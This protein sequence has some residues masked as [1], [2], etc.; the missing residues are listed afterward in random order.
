MKGI[1]YQKSEESEA[2]SNPFYK[3]MVRDE[4]SGR[5]PSQTPLMSDYPP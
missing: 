5:V 3:P 4:S 1:H 2:E